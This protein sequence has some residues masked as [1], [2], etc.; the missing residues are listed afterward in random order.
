ME[1]PI[2][3]A[4]DYSKISDKM[5][6]KFTKEVF[7]DVTTGSPSKPGPNAGVEW[8]KV[9]KT[10]LFDRLCS[11]SILSAIVGGV[12]QQWSAII[13]PAHYSFHVS[14][15]SHLKLSGAIPI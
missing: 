9:A 5:V 3:A 11:V 4:S 7:A 6:K 2:P 12:S 1:G 14:Q 8:T 15:I 13:K 10:H